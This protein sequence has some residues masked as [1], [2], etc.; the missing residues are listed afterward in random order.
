MQLIYQ[1]GE[2]IQRNEIISVQGKIFWPFLYT[3]KGKNL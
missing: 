1:F 3:L 2:N